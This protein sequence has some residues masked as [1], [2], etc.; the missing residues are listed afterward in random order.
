MCR[1]LSKAFNPLLGCVVHRVPGECD[2]PTL[3]RYL[4]DEAAYLEHA[5]VADDKGIFI[6]YGSR[7]AQPTR[8]CA[9]ID[10]TIERL[11]GNTAY[12]L[13][14]QE[15]KLAESAVRKA[16]RQRCAKVCTGV[17]I[18]GWFLCD[19]SYSYR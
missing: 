13:S 17:P 10:R 2:L 4:D 7:T 12:F 16:L 18:H 19:A 9:F 11:A 5:D 8:V 1:R 6:Y 14:P 15:F 3:S